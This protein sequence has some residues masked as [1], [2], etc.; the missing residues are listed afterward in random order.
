MPH[1]EGDE[2]VPGFR[3]MKFLGRGGIGEVWKATAPGKMFCALKIINLSA[4]QGRTEYRAVKLV[5]NIHHPH[6]VPMTGIW[7]KDRQG[8]LLGDEPRGDPLRDSMAFQ[9]ADEAPAQMI[10]QMG[11][12]DESLHDRLTTWQRKGQQGIPPDELL[13]Y[14]EEA[15]KGIDFLNTARH[16]LGRGPEAIS[17]GDIKPQNIM[18]VG[19]S[20]QVCDFGLARSLGADVRATSITGSPAYGSPE[21]LSSGK[22]VP[23]SDQY[24]LAISYFELRTGGLPFDDESYFSV[25]AAHTKGKLNL[26][27][28]PSA[29]RAVIARATALEPAARYESCLKMVRELRRAYEGSIAQ[30]SVVILAEPSA[31]ASA[32]AG[33]APA[34]VVVTPPPRSVLETGRE[35]LPHLKLVRRMF[36]V[37]VDEIWEATSSNVQ[38]TLFI[39]D[40]APPAAPPDLRTLA[41]MSKLE[42]PHLARLLSFW[43]FDQQLTPVGVEASSL[44]DAAWLVL[45][46]RRVER[47][48]GDRLEECRAE[49]LDGIP[50]DELLGHMLGAAQAIDYLNAMRHEIGSTRV[51][52]QH[53]HVRPSSLE[54]HG[55]GEGARVRLGNFTHARILDAEA[56]LVP[57]IAADVAHAYLPP[58]R[59][60]GHLSRWSDQFSLGVTYY[61]LRTGLPPHSPADLM[62]S[63]IDAKQLPAPEA[64]VL[65]RATSFDLEQR[66]ESCTEFVTLLGAAIGRATRQRLG[67]AVEPP[68]ETGSLLA[69]GPLLQ[70][71]L[72]VPVETAKP[73]ETPVAAIAPATEAKS[74]H[75]APAAP[76]AASPTEPAPT[77]PG[78]PVKKKKRKKLVEDDAPPLELTS[79]IEFNEAFRRM[80]S[81]SGPLAPLNLRAAEA[82]S[83]VPV[84]PALDASP[85][86]AKPALRTNSDWRSRLKKG[87]PPHRLDRNQVI[88]LA[89]CVA[90]VLLLFVIWL[91]SGPRN[92]PEPET[93]ATVDTDRL[94]CITSRL[95][96]PPS[97]RAFHP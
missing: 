58:E 95:S 91:F 53:G 68:K 23:T 12:G 24:S 78:D 29:E 3:L 88:I 60:D 50:P 19:G 7:L 65:L 36:K 32:A 2:I 61:H 75:P 46:E 93:A 51:A 57:Q 87:K 14:M 84:A 79:T 6:L 54:L 22:N 31:S 4:K 38:T 69:P 44:K 10:I 18:L 83:P 76:A 16:D 71:P 45:S 11:L 21:S 47:T 28:L 52:V 40:L 64:N 43:L 67:R 27:A 33:A 72:P 13:D 41:L 49:G 56:I 77:S 20:A 9:S 5:K 85:E 82:K 73:A 15:A 63:R 94:A 80:L 48:L 97:C 92:E 17:H 34:S 25:I 1:A 74:A 96:S 30:A 86:P 26:Q 37:G 62:A 8:K 39:R 55:A 66:Y 35:L 81:D 59:I 42:H 89:F 70:V 90:A